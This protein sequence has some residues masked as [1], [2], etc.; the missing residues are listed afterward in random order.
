MGVMLRGWLAS[1][2][3][4]RCASTE[5]I[6]LVPVNLPAFSSTISSLNLISAREDLLGLGATSWDGPAALGDSVM[7]PAGEAGV[8]VLTV[9]TA[10]VVKEL[11]A[12]LVLRVLALGAGEGMATG[13][14]TTISVE[15]RDFSA[16]LRSLAV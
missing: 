5:A 6:T 4:C 11:A 14:S 7:A 16:A 12:L 15:R 10:A 8:A 13:E 3:G 1:A 9:L 2:R